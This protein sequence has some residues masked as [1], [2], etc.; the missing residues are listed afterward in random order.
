MQPGPLA[1]THEGPRINELP[2]LTVRTLKSIS[3]P[4]NT[5]LLSSGPAPNPAGSQA[6]VL[7]FAVWSGQISTSQGNKSLL[8]SVPLLKG[9]QMPSAVGSRN[10]HHHHHQPIQEG[11]GPQRGTSQGTNAKKA[12]M[13]D[14]T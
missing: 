9:Q 11:Q 14:R 12:Q 2:S 6:T 3:G 13:V 10:P 7:S 1:G 4:E 5:Q 8:V